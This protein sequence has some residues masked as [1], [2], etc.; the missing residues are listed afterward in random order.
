MQVRIPYKRGIRIYNIA[1][2][3]RKRCIRW[4]TCRTYQSMAS[5]VT[6]SPRM[7]QPIVTQIATKIKLEMKDISSQAHDSILRDSVEAVKYFHWETVMLE[8]QRKMS[9]L[10]CM[11]LLSLLVQQPAEKKPL[12]CFLASQLL[13]TR[14][15]HMGLVQ[16]AVSVMM[17][18]NGT[19]KQVH[20]ISFLVIFN[21]SDYANYL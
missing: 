12:L 7:L 10:T 18:V 5:A 20:F 21:P 8:L 15:P 2:P 16:R 3:S 17:Y 4:I 19:A 6:S 1:T 14:H 13:K 11:S 9:T